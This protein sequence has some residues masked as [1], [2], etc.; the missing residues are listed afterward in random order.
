LRPSVSPVI[1][2]SSYLDI[3]T[4]M[5]NVGKVDNKGIDITLNTHN[6]TTKNFQWST[7][8]IFSLNRNKV[9]SL[10]NYGTPIYPADI[11]QMIFLGGYNQACV[12]MP[13][14][15]IGVFY[16]YVTEGLY[17]S[18]EDLKNSA[19]PGGQ[20]Y[21]NYDRSSGIW[22][23]DVKYKDIS[24]PNGTPDGIIDEHD[25]TIIGDPNPDFT[26]GF[27]NTFIYKGWELNIGLTGAVGGDIFNVARMKMERSQILWDPQSPTV[28]GRAQLGY[29]DGDNA[30]STNVDNCYIINADENPTL[31]RF[32]S[33]ENHNNWMSDRWI[34]DGS[35]LRIQNITLAYSF[36]KQMIKKAGMQNCKLYVSAQNVWTFT[37]Y[38]GYDPEIGSFNQ[39][40]GFSNVDLGRYPAPRVF[41]LGAN[42]TF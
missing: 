18:A 8:L 11:Q 30:N 42:I 14:Q 24:G 37:K 40:A 6:I 33:G 10:D 32:M 25:Q 9:I 22:V 36:P 20:L 5:M 34:E 26:F 19:Q 7:N 1:G 17:M 16:G 31:P 2:G 38:S 28:L 27:N 41:T 15:P 13:G 21:N 29:T 39:N 3:A 23:G 4:A 12:I 35:Y